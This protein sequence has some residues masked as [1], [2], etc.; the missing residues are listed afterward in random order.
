[1]KNKKT[2]KRI[3]QGPQKAAVVPRKPMSDVQIQIAR[4]LNSVIDDSLRNE[5]FELTM[6]DL[7]FLMKSKISIPDEYDKSLLEVD[8]STIF[9]PSYIQI[10]ISRKMPKILQ[11][12]AVMVYSATECVLHKLGFH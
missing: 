10:R 6:E 12:I 3:R 2:K 11:V 1:M 7:A 5:A 9:N 8:K 4:R